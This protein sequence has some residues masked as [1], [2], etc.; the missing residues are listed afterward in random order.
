MSAAGGYKNA[1]GAEPTA[2]IKAV[3]E[4]YDCLCG[5]C[6]GTLGAKAKEDKWKEIAKDCASQ[7][8]TRWLDKT[9]KV[10]RDDAWGYYKKRAKEE[11]KGCDFHQSAVNSAAD[12]GHPGN[13]FASEVSR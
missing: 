4:Q 9:P 3:G 11:K 8:Y 5:K 10:L 1:S 2:F 6:G 7:G 12:V 13:R